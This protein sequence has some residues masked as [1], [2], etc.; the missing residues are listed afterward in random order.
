MKSFSVRPCSTALRQKAA[1]SA[2][3]VQAVGIVKDCALRNSESEPTAIAIATAE[4]AS[5]LPN[6]IL[7]TRRARRPEADSSRLAGAKKC[8]AQHDP[9]MNGADEIRLSKSAR[10]AGQPRALRSRAR[11][12]VWKSLP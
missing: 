7:P 8:A 11:R 1:H 3:S 5:P 12:G 2:A 10:R 4:A 6:L 9:P